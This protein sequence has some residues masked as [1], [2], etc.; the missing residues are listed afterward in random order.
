MV[1]CFPLAENANNSICVQT[2]FELQLPGGRMWHQLCDRF[3]N[4]LHMQTRPR[5]VPRSLNVGQRIGPR[6][7]SP[8]AQTST[9][10]PLH[11]RTRFNPRCASLQPADSLFGSLLADRISDGDEISTQSMTQLLD[12]HLMKGRLHQETA[13]SCH[14]L[15]ALDYSS[16]VQS[17]SLKA[18]ILQVLE[19]FL[20]WH[21]LMVHQPLS[22]NPKTT[23]SQSKIVFCKFEEFFLNFVISIKLF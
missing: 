4:P 20:L 8:D 7:I 3:N 6:G 19:G 23:S 5:S 14:F 16:G 17:W 12:C 10:T 11:K 15:P 22:E 21:W 18:A 2:Q 9:Q 1:G 13:W